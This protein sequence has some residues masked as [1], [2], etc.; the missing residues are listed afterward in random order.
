MARRDATTRFK[1]DLTNPQLFLDDY[2]VQDSGR[3]E[4]VWHQPRKYPDP[5]LAAEHP[6]ER[7]CPV[8]YGTVLHHQGRFRMWYCNWTRQVPPHVAYAESDDGIHWCK[9][10][11][12]IH[13]IL[14]TK[15]NNVV[16]V[17]EDPGCL[18]DDITVIDDPQDKRWPLKALFWDSSRKKTEK[19]WGI[20]AA[21]SNDG[22]HWERLG[23]VLP[24]WGDRFNALAEKIDGRYLVLAR[25]PNM[26]RHGK[27]RIVSRT[28]SRNL[29]EWSDARVVL[30]K[31]N[32][33]PV[34][35][36]FYSATAFTY[37]DILMG[38]IERM[39]MVPD[40]LDTEII[41]SRDTGRTW[42][43]AR[44]RPSFIPWGLPGRWD[45]TWINL[46]AN[47]PVRV[48]G[49]L[50]F[51]YSG[52]SG[53]HGANYPHNHGAIGLAT[54][55]AD[56]FCSLKAG[57]ISGYVLTRPLTWP[58]GRLAVNVDMR[59]DLTAHPHNT[60]AGHFRVEVRDAATGKPLKGFS[61]D[62]HKHLCRNTRGGCMNVMWGEDRS[63]QKLAGKTIQ[64]YFELRD[65]HL[66][67]FKAEA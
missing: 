4:R 13:E 48:G 65:T 3:V 9:P 41:W 60:L 8:A 6:W 63:L 47:G 67:A 19:V 40:R 11:L 28:Q 51:Y 20:H 36:Q 22:I 61:L 1:P 50:W 39:H 14:G 23:C 42:H 25:E 2:W 46:T 7:N 37:G 58:G 16:L 53:A 34:D 49:D 38:S 54:L 32:E 30:H 29:T 33:D 31:D 35:M 44:T 21:R 17:A 18:I 56:G 64:L 26:M 62:E 66:Y 43:R 52:R 24:Q 57:E 15:D 5:V 59:R 27:G 10:R 45:D 55:R 12:G